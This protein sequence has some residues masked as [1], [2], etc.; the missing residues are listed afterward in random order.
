VDNLFQNDY[1]TSF[2]LKKKSFFV[3]I[4]NIFKW[5]VPKATGDDSGSNESGGTKVAVPKSPFP[6]HYK[7]FW[8]KLNVKNSY[9]LFAKVL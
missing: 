6:H 4:S 1:I 2:K 9:L 7:H 8:N 5:L 3:P